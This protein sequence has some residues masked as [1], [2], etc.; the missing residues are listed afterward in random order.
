MGVAMDMQENDKRKEMNMKYKNELLAGLVTAIIGTLCCAIYM[1]S[2]PTTEAPT[3]TTTTTIPADHDCERDGHVWGPVKH[4]V[5]PT[6]KG[7]QILRGSSTKECQRC[8]YHN[9]QITTKGL[10]IQ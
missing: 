1:H 4:S 5:V 9:I 6:E 10:V 8:D 7:W 3:T 2:Y